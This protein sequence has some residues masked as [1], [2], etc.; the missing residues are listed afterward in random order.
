M[1]L[2]GA[3]AGALLL[4][5]HLDGPSVDWSEPAAWLDRVPP[6]DAVIALVRL[7]ALV[8]AG[9]LVVTTALYALATI[10]RV[11]ALIRGVRIVTLP[12]VRRVVDGA[13]A[14][15]LVASTASLAFTTAPASAQTSRA[16]AHA[17]VP[18]VATASDADA[19]YVPTPAGDPPSAPATSVYVVRTGDNLWTIAAHHLAKREEVPAAQ[20]SVADVAGFWR[21]L[22]ELNASSLAS[23]DPNV[24]FPGETIALP[25]G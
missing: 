11:P 14:A 24:I 9:Y 15:T 18:V 6:E 2:V 16:S 20:I 23:G 7:A 4:L 21:E 1:A 17:Y 25:G 22:V 12:S 10:T 13:L 3:E 5:L 19:G 8:T